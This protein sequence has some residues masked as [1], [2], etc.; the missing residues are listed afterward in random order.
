MVTPPINDITTGHFSQ[1]RGRCVLVNDWHC[2]STCSKDAPVGGTLYVESSELA[3]AVQLTTIH[4]LR[5]RCWSC[6]RRNT[7]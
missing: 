5:R 2:C 1:D 4:L 6:G 3:N 7:I